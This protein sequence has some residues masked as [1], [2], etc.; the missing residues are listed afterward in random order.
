MNPVLHHLKNLGQNWGQTITLPS[1]PEGDFPENSF[2]AI[3][4]AAD[5]GY[6]IEFDVHLTKDD[7]PVVFHDDTLSRICGVKGYLRDY[8]YEELQ[9]FRL[10]GTEERIPALTDILAMVNGRVPLII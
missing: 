8:T 2:A 1:N 5:L 3:K 7:I 6:G 4:R 9:Q 10:L